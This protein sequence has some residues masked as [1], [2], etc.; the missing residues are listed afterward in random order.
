MPE[1]QVVHTAEL[2]LKSLA[3]HLVHAAVGQTI[4]AELRIRHTRRWSHAESPERTPEQPLEF[5]Y[6]IH[7]NPDVWLV[8]GR[9]RGNFTAQE[10]ETST[11]DLM[12]LPQR[13]GH[14][15]LPGVEIKT[16]VSSPPPVLAGTSS[17]SHTMGTDPGPT[18]RR[19]VPCEVDYRNH[20]ETLLVLPDLCKT[21]VSLPASGGQ[22]G[23]GSWLVESERRSRPGPLGST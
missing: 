10:G 17:G 18:H 16:F 13:P 3:S 15:L 9:R 8:G 23:G 1:V 20:A 11:F 19:P 5:S 2:Q 7:A 6:E 4:P 21:T 22:A 14:L 12:L